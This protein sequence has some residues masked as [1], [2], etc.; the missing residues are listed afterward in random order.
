M[1]TNPDG[2][3]QNGLSKRYAQKMVRMILIKF[4]WDMFIF[5]DEKLRFQEC[6]FIESCCETMFLLGFRDE[7]SFVSYAGASYGAKV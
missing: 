5:Y 4:W 7:T 3:L 1:S 6:F 2:W